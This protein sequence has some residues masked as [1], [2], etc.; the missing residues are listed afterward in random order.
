MESRLHGLARANQGGGIG[1]E[2]TEPQDVYKR[3]LTPNL[4]AVTQVS[5]GRDILSARPETP[6]AFE[7]TLLSGNAWGQ[8]PQIGVDSRYGFTLGNPSRFGAGSYPDEHLYQAQE[9]LDWVRGLSL[10]H[11]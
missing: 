5:A 10:I 6:S 11:I 3:Q 7:Q 9:G 2:R 8:L 1:Y 4:L